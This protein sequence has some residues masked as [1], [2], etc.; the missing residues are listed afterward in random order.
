M[1]KIGLETI[2]TTE[3]RNPA[4]SKSDDA[5]LRPLVQN[6]DIFSQF[7]PPERET[8]WANLKNHPGLI[9]SFHTFFEDFK[10]LE[11]L[12]ECVKKLIRPSYRQTT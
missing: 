11:I 1:Q 9:P 2:E 3:L 4:N 6:G 7:S 10:Y 5:F 8:I 12:A